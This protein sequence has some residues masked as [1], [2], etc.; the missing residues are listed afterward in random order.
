MSLNICFTKTAADL[1]FLDF[2]PTE[3]SKDSHA[4]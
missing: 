2:Y 1:E 4:A 3:D